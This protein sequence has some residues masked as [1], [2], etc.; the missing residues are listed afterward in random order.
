M[1]TR[2]CPRAWSVVDETEEPGGQQDEGQM[3]VDMSGFAGADNGVEYL[4]TPGGHDSGRT[5]DPLA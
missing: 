5:A 4:D 3:V 1:E 2:L